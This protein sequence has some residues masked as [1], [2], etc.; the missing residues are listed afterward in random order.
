MARRGEQV[1][2]DVLAAL[3]AYGRPTSAY[4]LLRDLQEAYPKMAP[5][6]IYRA[7]SALVEQGKVH[8]LESLNAF[9]ACQCTHHDQAA[10][11]SICD[12]CGA[13]EETVAPK[14]LDQLTQLTKKSGFKAVRHI[15]E[16]HGRCASCGG[17]EAKA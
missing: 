10:I 1:R 12:D 5:P 3:L 7:L 17:S 11:L 8:R 16:I 14:L 2:A 9:V 4:D 6:T 13:V 15:I